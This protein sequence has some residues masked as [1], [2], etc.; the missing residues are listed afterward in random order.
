MIPTFELGKEFTIE[1][2]QALDEVGAVRFT[3]VATPAEVLA[4][5]EAVEAL[6]EQWV[7]EGRKKVNGIPLK[8]GEQADGTR[9]VQRFAFSSLFSDVIKDFV[10]DERFE[11]VRRLCGEDCRVGD[12]EKDGVVINWYRN[13]PGSHYK[14]LGWHTD[15]LRDL[16]YGKLPGPM[17]NIGF[18]I[19]DSP[20]EKGALRLIP[21][22][23]KQGFLKMA[24]AK[25]Y[26]IDHREDPNEVV[27]ET[28]AGDLTVH[29][30]RLWHR[31]GRSELEGDASIRRTMY[32]PYLEGP[33]KPKSEDSKTPIYHHLQWLTSITG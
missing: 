15:G 25:P 9:F 10:H 19:D 3:N 16:A 27:L 22:S 8:Y 11:P 5:Q 31:V 28:K 6:S 21:G 13:S 4:I 26:F 12:S 29:D 32:V 7:R 24:F 1:Q 23:H 30:G 14:A 17:Y 18:S 2:R 20:K 33:Y